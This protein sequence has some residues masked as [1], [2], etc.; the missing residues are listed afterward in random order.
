MLRTSSLCKYNLP[1]AEEETNHKLDC[2]CFNTDA[3]SLHLCYYIF[4]QTSLLSDFSPSLH[5]S[6]G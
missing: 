2:T 6:S 4:T 3:L 1:E 5:T